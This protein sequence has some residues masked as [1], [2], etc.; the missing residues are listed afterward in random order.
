MFGKPFLAV[1]ALMVVCGAVVSLGKPDPA[2]SFD[3]ARQLWSDVLRDADDLGLQLTRVS[4]YKE[5]QLGDQMAGEVGRWGKEDPEA[6]RYVAAVGARLVPGVNRKAIRYHFHVLQSPGVNAFALPGGHIYVLSGM[7]D[8][9]QSEAELAAI[10]GHEMSHVDL[11]HCIEQYQYQLA[12]KN[13]GAEDVGAIAGL[14]H[15]LVAIGYRQDQEL[16]ADL[17]GQRLAVEAGY[18]PYAAPGVFRRM[19]VRFR[20]SAAAPATTPAD[21]LSQAIGEA[22]GSYF[23]THPPSAERARQLFQMAARDRRTLAGQISYRGIRN[24]RERVARSEREFPEEQHV[25]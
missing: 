18:D 17:S 10:L 5:M 24:Y 16:E 25:E 7:L 6:T 23:R 15:A 3:S 19:Q 1:L 14:A 21:E 13:V 2:V 4:A 8:F 22:L 12:L 11:R 20:E 9:L